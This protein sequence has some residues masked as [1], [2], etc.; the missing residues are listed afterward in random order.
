MANTVTR[1]ALDVATSPQRLYYP[2]VPAS[3]LA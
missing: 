3:V 2:V 1:R